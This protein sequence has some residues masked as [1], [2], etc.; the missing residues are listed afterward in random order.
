MMVGIVVVSLSWWPVVMTGVGVMFGEI[1]SIRDAQY[2][3]RDVM[4]CVCMT[5]GVVWELSSP[6]LV[7]SRG[8]FRRKLS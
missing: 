1:N 4:A 6:S 8:V 3:L 7:C 2:V 5:Y